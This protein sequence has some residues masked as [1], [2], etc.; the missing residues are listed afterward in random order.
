[1]M[2][3]HDMH[4]AKTPPTLRH[5]EYKIPEGKLVVVDLQVIEGVLR[6]VQ[7]SGDFFME[8]PDAL[9]AINLALDGMPDDVTDAQL[10]QAVQ[11]VTKD[12]VMYGINAAGI[13][14]VVRRA[15]A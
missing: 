3:S 8:P 7:L 11:A 2:N 12:V 15:L 9:D 13:A 14:V 1:M 10:E 6:H 4:Q 5:G